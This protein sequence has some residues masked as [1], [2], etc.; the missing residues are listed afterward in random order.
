MRGMLGLCWLAALACNP[1][2]PK[3]RYAPNGFAPSD[4][5]TGDTDTTDPDTTDPGTT[6]GGTTTGS[7][8]TGS[9]TTGSTTTG[10][11][12]TGSTTTGSTTTGG[13]IQ[14]CYPGP[15]ELYDVC[16]DV[17]E[18]YP[19]P[20]EYVY[21]APLGGDPQY[22]APIRYLDLAA[23][24]P[25]TAL[26][27]NF[28][29][30]EIAQE[31]KGQWAVVQVQTLEHLQDM[32]DDLGPLVIN[33]GYRN[34]DYNAS[35]GGA[36][37]SRHM[38]GDGIDIDP[39]D[40]TLDD[41]ADSCADNGSGYVELYETHVHC[42]WRDDPLD[43]AFYDASLA[44]AQRAPISLP[45]VDLHERDGLWAADGDRWEEGEPLRQWTAYDEAGRVIDSATGRT[46]TPP[47]GAAEVEVLVG[48]QVRVRQ[49]L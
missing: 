22:N 30:D 15:N 11:T 18:L 20:A 38:Y 27:P 4:P 21:P 37:S 34:P 8:T 43:P 9:T 46:Y 3:L 16:L 49:R 5:V 36:S 29:L 45:R 6:T 39:V 47:E 44:F 24:D 25:S 35:I 31:Y 2:P 33:S 13:P 1:P 26:A 14:A 23:I 32:R 40:V 19:T 17:V 12:T 48:G 7:T 10:S 28:V 42:D 41:V